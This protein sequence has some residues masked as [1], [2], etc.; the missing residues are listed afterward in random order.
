MI[1]QI[2]VVIIYWQKE[3]R[4]QLIAGWLLS[5]EELKNLGFH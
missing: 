2:L 4:E 5:E 1:L 3:V